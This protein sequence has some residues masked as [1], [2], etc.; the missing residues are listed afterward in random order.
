MRTKN[1]DLTRSK[2]LEAGFHEVYEHGFRAASLD[3]ILERAGVTKG[4]LYHHFPNK[5]ALGYAIVEE[6]IGDFM[7]ELLLEPLQGTDDPIT[8]LQQ[9][10][11]DILAGRCAEVCSF[12]CP[13]NNLTQEMSGEDEGFRE[14]VQA[15][16]ER[17]QRGIA[18][19]LRRG[20]EA[21]KVRAGIDPDDVAL[22]FL[23]TWSGMMGVAKGSQDEE[24]MRRL[25]LTGNDYL[26]TLRALPVH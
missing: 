21:G 8:A 11:M 12:G 15:V 23:A 9:S 20:Q 17:L 1:P 4:A 18:A 6:L 10:G 2:L 7:A 25:I 24:L 14:R 19:A 16:H 13:L 22:Y 5:L 26:E 3:S